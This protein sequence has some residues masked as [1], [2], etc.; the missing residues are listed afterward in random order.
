M[1][2]Q[3]GHLPKPC[4]VWPDDPLRLCS[5]VKTYAIATLAPR[6]ECPRDRQITPPSSSKPFATSFFE[7]LLANF[8]SL[9]SLAYS[10]WTA[11]AAGLAEELAQFISSNPSGTYRCRWRK[12]SSTLSQK[13]LRTCKCEVIMGVLYQCSQSIENN[14]LSHNIKKFYGQI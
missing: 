3:Q 7:G 8:F 11:S 9:A 5:F 1:A 10:P 4:L 6:A 12:M 13:N 2:I 14:A